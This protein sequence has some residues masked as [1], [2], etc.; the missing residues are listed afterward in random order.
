MFVFVSLFLS[1]KIQEAPC[2]KKSVG[3]KK[4]E[5]VWRLSVIHNLQT[6]T[7]EPPNLPT[8]ELDT[9]MDPQAQRKTLYDVHNMTITSIRKLKKTEM[10]DLFSEVHLEIGEICRSREFQKWA[11]SPDMDGGPLPDASPSLRDFI[12]FK[13]R[14]LSIAIRQAV[15][16]ESRAAKLTTT[17]DHVAVFQEMLDDVKQTMPN[18]TY[19]L[20][21]EKTR[22]LYMESEW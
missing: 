15:L 1:S 16:A 8:H 22:K 3:Q 11:S 13:N 12:S 21:C 18:E 14:C 7:H 2:A 17:R 5:T 6:D 4:I 20:L 9:T 10:A 19:R